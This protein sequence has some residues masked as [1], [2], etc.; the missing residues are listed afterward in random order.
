MLPQ[1]PLQVPNQVSPLAQFFQFGLYKQVKPGFTNYQ[2]TLLKNE[3]HE[4]NG[5][6]SK[7]VNN[8]SEFLFIFSYF[9]FELIG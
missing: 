2:P 3:K 5:I 9:K 8:I 1:T 7:I 6:F 4:E